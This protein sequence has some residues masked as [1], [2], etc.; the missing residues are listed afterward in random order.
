MCR[1]SDWSVSSPLVVHINGT[2][3]TQ[4]GTRR[5]STSK[6]F[7]TRMNRLPSSASTAPA[8]RTNRK[9]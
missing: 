2:S 4:F 6:K 9:R 5:F 3:K 8:F 7:W 1:D